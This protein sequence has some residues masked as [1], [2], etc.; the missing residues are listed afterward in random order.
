MLILLPRFTDLSVSVMVGL[1]SIALAMLSLA[2][3][4]YWHQSHKNIWL[5]LSALALWASVLTK[6]FTGFLAPIFL[7]GIL[8]DGY[9][10]QRDLS[11]WRQ[12]LRPGFQWG[13]VLTA[14]IIVPILL[15]VRPENI[16]QLLNDHLISAQVA[17]FQD[18][19]EYGLLSQL[20]EARLI[21]GLAILGLIDSILQKRWL[22]L[23]PAAW[24]I[25]AFVLLYNHT[26]VW[27]HQQLLITIPAVI[28]AAGAAGDALGR[29]EGI[30]RRKIRLSASDA[31]RFASLAVFVLIIQVRTPLIA[32][33][34]NPTPAFQTP[35]IRETSMEMTVLNRIKQYADDTNWLLTDLPIFAF[36][37]DLPVPPNLVVFSNK[38]VLTESLTEAEVLATLAELQPEQVLFGRVD[39]PSVRQYLEEHYQLIYERESLYLYLINDIALVT[40]IHQ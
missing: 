24:M 4:V 35:P 15:I 13:L 37:A 14:V 25:T 17:Q 8:I 39:F 26:P 31:I 36:Y 34:F 11:Q 29:I 27:S 10:R 7:L 40:A 9:Q 12:I 18:P 23:Y 21:L 38:R 28:L 20:Y 33:V 1:P 19:L 32:A 5:V 30:L 6:L 2:A 16:H 3:L 22:A